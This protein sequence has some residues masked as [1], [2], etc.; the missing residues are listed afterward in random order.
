[1]HKNSQRQTAPGRRQFLAKSL[2][3]TLA[4][5]L[6]TWCGA[7]SISRSAGPADPALIEDLVAAN[8]ILVRYG[9]LDGMGHVSVRH[10]ADPERF[11]ISRS[12]APELV[13]AA[14]ILEYDLDGDAIDLRGRAQYSER[15]IHAAIYRARPDVNSVVHNHS[16]AVIPFTVSDVPM[17]PIYHMA[18]FMLEGLPVFDIRDESGITDM[19]VSSPERA[20][21]LVAALG[22]SAAVLMR[23]H[24]IA[25]TGPSL[26]FSV[27]RSIYTQIN[28]DLQQRAIALGGSVEYLDPLEAQAMLDAGENRGYSRSWELWKRD[29]LASMR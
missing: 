17:R 22:D 19:L 12:L 25:V 29:A 15:Y 28:A 5:G 10:N 14:D 4:I 16:P 27:G 11:L 20:K 18:S 24:G 9:V 1:V 13:T 7:Q 23:G 21:G 26:P 3:T 2:A 6:P 8:R